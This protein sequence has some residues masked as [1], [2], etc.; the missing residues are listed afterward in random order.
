VSLTGKFERLPGTATEAASVRGLFDPHWVD[1]LSGFDASRSAFLSRNLAQ[2]R[3][4]HVAA[5]A[6]S[7]LNAPQ[8]SALI[9]SLRNPAGETISG[10]VFAGEFLLQPLNADLVVLSACNTALGRESAG[11]G[12][13]GLRYAVHAAGARSVIASLWEV[14]DQPAATV[15]SEFYRRYVQSHESPAQALAEAMRVGQQT[16]EDPSLWGA[17]DLSVI[18]PETLQTLH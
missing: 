16:Y 12:L 17:Y 6:R 15:I 4:I 9:L 7:D 3:I 10:E 18:G 11:E 2:Y 1:S 13:L 14:P 8:L 5:H